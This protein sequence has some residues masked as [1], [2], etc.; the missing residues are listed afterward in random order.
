[1]SATHDLQLKNPPVRFVRLTVDFKAS[2]PIQNWHLDSFFDQ[3]STDYSLREEVAPKP[4][5]ESDG[6]EVVIAATRDWPIPRTVLSRQSKTLEVQEDQLSVTWSFDEQTEDNKYPGFETLLGDITGKLDLLRRS[7]GES[8]NDLEPTKVEC[9]YGNEIEGV[10]GRDLLVGVL[11]EWKTA[12]PESLSQELEDYVGVR[13]HSTVGEDETPFSSTVFVDLLAHAS[14]SLG[15]E[16]SKPVSGRD[17]GYELTLIHD[18]VASMFLK[19][20]SDDLL[21]KWRSE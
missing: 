7:L 18:H 15:F 3:V 1:M 13:I 9:F 16:V 4:S 17:I 12:V 2:L 8:A 11:T 19:Y 20:V 6:Q 21:R 5:A 10:S 14:P